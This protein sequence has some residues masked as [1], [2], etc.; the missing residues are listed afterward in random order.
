MN[1]LDYKESKRITTEDILVLF[2]AFVTGLVFREL[3][4]LIAEL[5]RVI[6]TY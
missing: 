1:P 4:W 3:I 6:N 2:G 5:G